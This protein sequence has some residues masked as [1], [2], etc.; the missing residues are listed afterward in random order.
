M[1]MILRRPRSTRA[2]TYRSTAVPMGHRMGIRRTEEGV[3]APERA[4][5]R[6]ASSRSQLR[7][8]AGFA[9]DFPQPLSVAHSR[10]VSGHWQAVG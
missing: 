1:G 3:L 4:A 10:D 2:D 8:S 5:R 7:V 6:G 9:P